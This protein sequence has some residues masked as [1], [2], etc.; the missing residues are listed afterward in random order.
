MSQTRYIPLVLIGILLAVFAGVA[1]YLRIGFAH[2]QVFVGDQVQF[3]ETDAYYHMRLV[4]NL[5]HHFPTRIT[6][7]PYTYYP[8]GAPVPWPPFFDW[9]VAGIAWI[10]GM[11]S[12]TQHTAEVIGAWLPAILG[13]LAVIPVYFVG[14]VLFNRWVGVIAAGLIAVHPG[15]F[16]TYSTLGFCDHHVAEVLFSTLTMLFLILSLKHARLRQLTF[17][18]MRRPKPAILGKPLLY[19]L[20]AGL[21]FG[22][23][24]LTWVGGLLLLFILFIY[25]QFNR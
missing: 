14:K 20:L 24:L 1:L 17:T 5:L 19:S 4:D 25:F 6:F 8:H 21:F 23:Y 3:T 12:P 9:L 22:I 11:G 7:D 10:F 13:A 2:D 16:L 18:D 15:G